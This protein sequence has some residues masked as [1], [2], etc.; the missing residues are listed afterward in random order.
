MTATLILI[1]A[2]FFG[3]WQSSYFGHNLFPKSEAEVLADGITLALTAL[4][5]L[6][7]KR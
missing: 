1:L 3:F 4:G 7:W 6:A 5:I 2:A